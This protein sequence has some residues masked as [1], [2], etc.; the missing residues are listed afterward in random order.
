[1]D[2][3]YAAAPMFSRPFHQVARL[4][5][6]VGV[7][8]A[9]VPITAPAETPDAFASRY[10]KVDDLRVHYLE[11]GRGEPVILLHGLPASAEMWRGAGAVLA[12]YY[13]VIIPDA[14]G[15]GLTQEGSGALSEGRLARDVIGLMDRLGIVRA[16]V[17]GHSMG[18]LTTIHLI[19]DY[20]DRIASAI[21]IGS[22]MM[23]IK[24]STPGL[25]AMQLSLSAL[26]RGQ[27]VDDPVLNE[28]RATYLRTTPNPE[29]FRAFTA[30]LM[31][32]SSAVYDPQVLSLILTPTLVLIAGQDEL[33]PVE[34]F[35]ALAAA[36]P[37]ARTAEFPTG[38]HVIPIE[39]PA[40]FAATVAKF[41]KDHPLTQSTP[42]VR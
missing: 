17:V 23:S 41:L 18:S 3:T 36:I 5:V 19:V 20:P 32:D 24:A 4:A 2:M 34:Q 35:R 6:L 12:R 30:R 27:P 39:S 42:P 9:S 16:H 21:L 29:R 14:R 33:I 38:T 31:A 13:H 11:A 40:E 10:V 28:F 15:R 1:M 26:A 25:Q 22:P 37:G 8:L 7:L